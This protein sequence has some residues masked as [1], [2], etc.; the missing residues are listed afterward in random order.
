[1]TEVTTTPRAARAAA[2][3]LVEVQLLRKFCPSFL[4]VDGALV[5]NSTE[6]K[7]VLQPGV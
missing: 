2:P 5:S 1:M 4:V 3:K 7:E 6:I